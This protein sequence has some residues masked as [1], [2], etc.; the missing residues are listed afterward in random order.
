MPRISYINGRYVN[1]SDAN[2]HIEDRGYV[3]SDAIYEVMAFYNQKLLDSDLHIE[4]LYRSLKELKI[5]FTPS[6]QSIIIIIRELI[7]RNKRIDGTIYLQISRGVARR[8]HPF[9][10]NAK[11]SLVMMITGAKS[12]KKI[13]VENGVGVITQP[14]IRWGRRDIKSVSLLANVLAKQ[15]AALAGV[16][17][18]WL[19][20]ENN[21]IT[22]GAVSNNAIIN[23]KGEIITHPLNNNILGGVTRNVVLRLAKNNGI[24]VIERAFSL[25]EALA[26][27]EAFLTSTTSNILPVVSINGAKIASGKRGDITKKLQELYS[28][29][30]L[31]ET[32]KK[33]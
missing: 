14:D 25:K 17:E 6:K 7:E 5:N 11:P 9:P 2:V 32:G 3:F 33:L 15:E 16:R 4:R 21:F 26:A 1:H 18:A 12:P 22:E 31:K 23:A 28:E 10:K 20:D 27:K 24:K 13:E 29:H 30:V 19:I 8:D